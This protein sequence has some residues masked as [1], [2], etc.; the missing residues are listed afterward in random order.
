M[1]TL[2]FACLKAQNGARAAVEFPWVCAGAPE[3]GV[4]LGSDGG[5][6]QGTLLLPGLP[7]PEE[8]RRSDFPVLKEANNEYKK[9]R[10]YWLRF[11][12]T[13]LMQDSGCRMLD[14]ESGDTFRVIY[15]VSRILNPSYRIRLVLIFLLGCDRLVEEIAAH[16]DQ[17]Q[18][19]PVFNPFERQAKPGIPESD[20]ARNDQ[21]HAAE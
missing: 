7:G 10:A 5:Y 6:Y 21:N 13:V 20:P 14:I 15:P 19:P 1:V 12:E 4:C 17:R 8:G 11:P 2:G 18:W 16:H 9:V 3:P